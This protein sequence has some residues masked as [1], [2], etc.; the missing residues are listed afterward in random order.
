MASSPAASEEEDY[1]GLLEAMR[2][3]SQWKQENMLK[4]SSNQ[5]GNPSVSFDSPVQPPPQGGSG[6][7]A[8]GVFDGADTEGNFPPDTNMMQSSGLP[9]GGSAPEDLPELAAEEGPVNSSSA[10]TSLEE[11]APQP[12]DEDLVSYEKN[13]TTGGLGKLFESNGQVSVTLSY[14]DSALLV[15]DPQTLQVV[16]RL[17][18][19]YLQEVD[20]MH[21]FGS[22]LLLLDFSVIE[23]QEQNCVQMYWY[24]LE[25]PQ[26]PREIKQ[27]AQSGYF[28]AGQLCGG[29]YYLV[30]RQY[31]FADV[32]EAESAGVSRLV[33]IVYDSADMT[34]PNPLPAAN[35]VLLSRPRSE[36]FFVV[37]AVTLDEQCST[38]F[39]AYFGREGDVTLFDG[40]FY[41]FPYEEE[42][43]VVLV[44]FGQEQEDEVVY[45]QAE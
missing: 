45:I 11:N 19:E 7:S 3:I 28:L 10:V 26:Q 9:E 20:E 1:A 13:P 5:A 32:A 8:G 21:L 35:I 12:E 27:I 43:E 2:Q 14:Q 16:S 40:G 41:L 15:Q 17:E 38:S 30:S 25:N 24:D 18:R 33:P 23:E 39:S 37:S 34:D 22:E 44:R 4:S 36:N 31:L 42:D 6:T 29:T